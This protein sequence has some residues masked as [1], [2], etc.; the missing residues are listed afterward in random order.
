MAQTHA[1]TLGEIVTLLGFMQVCPRRAVTPMRRGMGFGVNHYKE[2]LCRLAAL[3]RCLCT[4]N[5]GPGRECH[6]QALLSLREAM[7]PLSILLQEGGN[8]STSVSQA[9]LRSCS[10][11]LGD[12]LSS[13]QK[14]CS[15]LR[16]IYQLHHRLLKL[17]VPLVVKIHKNQPLSFSPS[18]SPGK[19]FPRAIPC[20]LLS[21]SHL[22]LWPGLLPLCSTLVPFLPPNH[23]SGPPTYLDVASSLPVVVQFSLSV[24]RSIFGVL[25]MI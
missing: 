2:P 3:S 6:L 23:A 1:V 12:L 14:F 4:S 19:C 11:P 25:R 15:T 20:V 9:I 24:L 10:L 16:T 17:L 8:F 18:M 13:L 22:S 21:L 7:P 5:E